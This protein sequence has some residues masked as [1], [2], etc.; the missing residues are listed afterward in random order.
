V[1][2]AIGH[3]PNAGERVVIDNLEIE[4]E[5]VANHAIVS[6]VVKRNERQEET[7]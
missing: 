6:V 3:V 2:E 4:V 7:S 5:R 1:L